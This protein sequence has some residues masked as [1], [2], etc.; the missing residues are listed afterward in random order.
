VKTPRNPQ[1][2][3][4]E[5]SRAVTEPTQDQNAKASDETLPS[6]P[7]RPSQ[8]RVPS[9][10]STDIERFV[11]K[12]AEVAR[13]NNSVMQSHAEASSKQD[14]VPTHK[15]DKESGKALLQADLK[16]AMGETAPSDKSPEI[17]NAGQD[18][19]N[20]KLDKESGKAVLEA[21]LKEARESGDPTE[22]GRDG[23]RDR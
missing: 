18:T 5:H 4:A 20:H 9:P 13:H 1:D 15:L 22:T 8:V 2:L 14:A 19:P 17:R 11:N 6:E 10:G 12:G 3:R 23:G 21:D 16:E 7:T